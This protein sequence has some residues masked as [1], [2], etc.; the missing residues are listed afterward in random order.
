[1]RWIIGI[2]EAGR[3]PLAG[4]VSAAAVLIPKS[5]RL[6]KEKL[7]DS[8]LLSKKQREEWFEYIRTH[9]QILYTVSRVY[10]ATI[11]KMNI[12]RATDLAA[13]RA[14]QKLL[15]KA[16][17]KAKAT[18][19]Y[20]DAGIKIPHPNTKT[21]IRGDERIKAIK[22]A[23]IVAKVTRDRYIER[24]HKEYPDYDLKNHKGYG[25]KTHTNAIKKHGPCPI[26]RLTF[27][28]NITT[29]KG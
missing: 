26:H 29:I 19:I 14:I 6:T 2:D 9:P 13:T 3:G 18:T 22:L 11:D 23:S 10:P 21:L 24:K 15:E 27:L 8:K 25:T 4:P 28:Q 1:M 20:L 5:I 17:K 12:A 16:N 7:R